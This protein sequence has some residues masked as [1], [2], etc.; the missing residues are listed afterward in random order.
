MFKGYHVMVTGATS[1]IGLGIV[2]EFL[3]QGAKVIGIGRNFAK[4]ENENLGENFIPCKCDVKDE[5]QIKAAFELVDKHFDGRL[6]TL[7]CNA[8]AGVA[9]S[10]ETVTAEEFDHAAYLLLR[11][12]M[13]FTKY[14]VPYLRKSENASICHTS[15]IGS[16]MISSPDSYLYSVFKIALSNYA[17]QS[18]AALAPIR[19]NAICPGLIKSNIMPQEAWDMLSTPDAM[20]MLPSARIADVSEVAKLVGFLS[21]KK[22]SY[23]SGDIIKI[24]GGWY[25]TYPKVSI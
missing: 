2:K 5:A 24:D 7:I 18:A 13:F 15:S 1:G 3:A 10:I 12:N 9:G 4:I 17:C 22:G 19:V 14:A 21:S 6:D 25:T 8:G 20:T 16:Y 11:S 23:I